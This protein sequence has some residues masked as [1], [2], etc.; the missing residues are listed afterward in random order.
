M[1]QKY[2]KTEGEGECYCHYSTIVQDPCSSFSLSRSL[3]RCL[4]SACCGIQGTARP[5]K[6]IQEEV[7]TALSQYA[8]PGADCLDLHQFVEM[9]FGDDATQVRCG[10]TNSPNS[11]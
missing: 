6:K 4:Y 8:T 1:I 11:P 9:L 10:I 5:G 7:D 2:Y 3:T